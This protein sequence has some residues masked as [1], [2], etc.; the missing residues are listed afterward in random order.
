[1]KQDYIG[2]GEKQY[3]TMPLKCNNKA[4]CNCLLRELD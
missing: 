2:P 3:S 4:E 1:M